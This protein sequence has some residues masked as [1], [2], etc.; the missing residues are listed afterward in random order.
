M[1][2]KGAKSLLSE[3]AKKELGRMNEPM[4]SR[5]KSALAGLGCQPPQGDI[6]RLA[7]SDGCWWLTGAYFT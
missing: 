1:E 6:K 3:Q 2:C 7:G 4:K 5:I